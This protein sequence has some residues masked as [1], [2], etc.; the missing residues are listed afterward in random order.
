MTSTNPTDEIPLKFPGGYNASPQA[1]NRFNEI[2]NLIE[3]RL[4]NGEP[5]Y[6]KFK[7]PRR[8]GAIGR[9]EHIQMIL[10]SSP[11]S[12]Y[13][14][15][16]V[17]EIRVVWDDRKNVVKPEARDVTFL[18]NHVG[19]TTWAWEQIPP[20]PKAPAVIQND[21]LGEV[22]EVGQFVSFIHRSYGNIKLKFGTV[23]RMSDKG[24]IWVNT[25]KLRDGDRAE[26][27]KVYSA[28]SVTIVN[29]NL[30]SRLMMARLATS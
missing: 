25:L 15:F 7:D 5:V 8:A 17:N 11:G 10:H 30:M 26:E 27:V 12:M 1:K 4:S 21:H 28:D 18:P 22:I 3:T 6:V 14:Y 29:D 13:T 16:T 24:T 20:K 2:K 19:G 9:I 23:S